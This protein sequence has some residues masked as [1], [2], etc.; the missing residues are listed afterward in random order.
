MA[1]ELPPSM[2][3]ALVEEIDDDVLAEARS[4]VGRPLRV[5]FGNTEASIDNIC[6]YALGLGDLNPLWSDTHYGERSVVAKNI[7]PPTFLYSVYYAPILPGFRERH[8][9]LSTPAP[10]GLF[11]SAC[12]PITLASERR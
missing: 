12:P 2:P 11:T 1:R 9:T 4:W 10:S 6:W 3:I 7:A 5:E 8:L